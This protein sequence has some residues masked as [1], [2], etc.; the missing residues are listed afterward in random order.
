M[1]VLRSIDNSWGLQETMCARCVGG[2]S[3]AAV[4]TVD[5][6]GT[7]TSVGQLLAAEPDWC[8][9]ISAGNEPLQSFTIMSR[10]WL[11]LEPSPSW[12]K[13]PTRAFTFKKTLC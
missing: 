4:M 6:S 12:L 8:A 1:A 10:K 5:R 2:I 9:S 11:I 7:R 3:Q 13:V